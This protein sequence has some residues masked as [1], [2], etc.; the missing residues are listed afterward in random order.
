MRVKSLVGTG[1]V[2]VALVVGPVTPA[3]AEVSEPDNGGSLPNALT[4]ENVFDA[5]ED[6]SPEWADEGI[7]Q[8]EDWCEM[9][10]GEED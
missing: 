7:D 10:T 3:S 6:N 2:A 9:I 5:L 8:V 4:C 1:A